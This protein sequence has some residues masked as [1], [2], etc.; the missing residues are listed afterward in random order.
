[1]PV[2]DGLYAGI[3]AGKVT[4]KEVPA[5][6]IVTYERGTEIKIYLMSIAVR[7]SQKVEGF[8]NPVYAQLISGFLDKLTDYA[9][10][11]SIFATHFLATA[12]TEKGKKM[13]ESLGMKQVGKD[14]FKDPIYEVEL[15]KVSPQEKGLQPALRQVLRTYRDLRK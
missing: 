14:K 10:H 1:M 7:E 5:S 12:W 6:G 15:A 2:R 9:K 4:D 3:V 11:R 13:C 8:W